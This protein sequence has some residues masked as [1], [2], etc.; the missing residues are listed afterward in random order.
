MTAGKLAKGVLELQTARIFVPLLEPRR[1]RGIKGG[2]G[3]GKSHFAAEMLI[4]ETLCS[5]TRA[6]CAREVQNSIKDSSKQLIEDKIAGMGVG[7]LFRVTDQEIRGPNDS[8]YIFKGL[9]NH[10]A[11]SIK[12][13]EGFNWFW[14]EEAQ[15]LSQRSID[16]AIPT[17]R[18]GARFLW[19]W[20][21]KTPKD[22]VDKLFR[23]NEGD[24]DFCCVEANYYDNPWFPEELR[25]DMERD[26]RRDP[27]KYTHVWLGKHERLSEARVF[28]N[29]RIGEPGEF[30]HRV[31]RYNLGADFGFSIDP[32][33]LVRC[34]IVG[35][36]LYVDREVY[37]IGCEIDHTPRLFDQIEDARKWPIVADSARP[38]TIS[39]LNRHGYPRVRASIKGAGSVVEGVEFL[40][41]YDIVVHPSCVHTI[42][43]LALY[44]FETDKLTGEVLPALADKKNHVIDALRYSVEN[45]RRGFVGLAR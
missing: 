27:D 36:T 30:T 28:R 10:T 31:A 35:R 9:Q 25:R 40:K 3:S 16:L 44:S 34:Y 8:L 19:T 6:V 32:T 7:H 42:D 18:K 23:E 11:Q 12:S 21:P 5:H 29:W 20:N 45:M 15:T 22:P 17:F 26:K 13:L 39:Y 37:K 33:V 1:Y 41:S 24:P 38:E 2:R 43:E 14:P 4:E